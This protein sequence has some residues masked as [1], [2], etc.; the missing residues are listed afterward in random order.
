MALASDL[1]KMSVLSGFMSFFVTFV[2]PIVPLVVEGEPTYAENFVSFFGV[3]F[4]SLV[5]SALIIRKLRA[6]GEETV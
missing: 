1:V 4:L 5:T 3:A 6:G 2:Q